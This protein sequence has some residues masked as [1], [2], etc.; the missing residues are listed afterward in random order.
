ML[1]TYQQIRQMLKRGIEQGKDQTALAQLADAF[2]DWGQQ[3][4]SDA[5]RELADWYRREGPHREYPRAN[6]VHYEITDALR[7]VYRQTGGKSATDINTKAFE[8]A[9]RDARRVI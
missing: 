4:A 3:K 9:L 8:A 7:E 2:E 6:V 5:V 1:P